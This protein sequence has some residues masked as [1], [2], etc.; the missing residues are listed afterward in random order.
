[1]ELLKLNAQN[2]PSE[3]VE[4]YDSLIWAERFN[5]IGDFELKT[6]FIPEFLTMLPDQTLI[7][8]SETSV[9][10][11]VENHRIDRPKNGAPVL[12]ISGR[13]YDSM[14][15][16]RVA[17][18]SITSE[19]KES[20]WTISG[21]TAA[22]VAYT[23]MFQICVA[24]VCDLAD[25]FSSADLQFRAHEDYQDSLNPLKPF[26]IPRGSLL[27]A[28]Q[29]LI[30]TEEP[31]AAYPYGQYGVRSIRPDRFTNYHVIQLYSGTD[32]TNTVY[33][34]ATQDLLDEGTYLFSRVNLANVAYGVGDGFHAKSFKGPFNPTG[35]N[36]RVMLVDV[37]SSGFEQL[38]LLQSEM[39]Q[40][41]SLA[42]ETALFDGT[43][44]E[45]LSPYIYNRD[46]FLGDIVSLVGDYGLS[47][48]A[49]VTEYIRSLDQNGYKAFPTLVTV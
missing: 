27:T 29:T 36:R 9:V 28:V 40:A 20:N 37:T 15:D 11:I 16:R 7:T 39:T 22:D 24:G 31:T 41:L 17:L 43:I 44:N 13:S 21:R 33:F 25:G 30:K 4:N 45:D 3:I 26:D 18:P 19:L 48:R 32:R 2:Q 10:M 35:I 34:D 14:L 1:M 42:R 8:L 49:R 46:Y 6:Q 38:S 12:T 23:L 5:D 47:E